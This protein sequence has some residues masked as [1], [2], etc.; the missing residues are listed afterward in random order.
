MAVA[1]VHVVGVEVDET[2]VV[3]DVML[4]VAHRGRAWGLQRYF[5]LRLSGAWRL[6]GE[7]KKDRG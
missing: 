1:R 7:S 2:I 6:L 4:L 5:A 3:I